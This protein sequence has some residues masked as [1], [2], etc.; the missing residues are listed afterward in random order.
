[1]IKTETAYN[2]IQRNINIKNKITRVA[3]RESLGRYLAEDIKSKINIP[4]QD[5]SAVDGIAINYSKYKNNPN[6]FYEIISEINAG[7][8]F[9][10]KIG[11]NQCV[12]VSTGAHLPNYLDTVIMIEDV[13]FL[14]N[15]LVELP[16]ILT[17]K[18]N[19]RKKGE[20]VKK[21]KIIITKKTVLRSQEIGLLASINKIT[22][23]VFAKIKIAL[24]SNGNELVNPGTTK[25]NNQIYDSN[26][27]MLMDLLKLPCNIITDSGILNDDYEKIKRKIITLKEKNDLI[28]ISGGASVGH[29]DYVV[30]IIKKIGKIIFSSLAIKPGRP[31]S[32]GILD[33]KVPI[34]ILPGN[35]VASFVTFY[36]FGNFILNCM[37]GLISKRPDFFLVK[38]NFNMMKKYGREEYLRG[39]LLRKKNE[40]FVNKYSTEGA[41]ILSSVVWSDGLIK[42]NAETKQIKVNDYLQFFPYSKI[43]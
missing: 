26:R 31:M 43:T 30:K 25:K 9:K 8:I 12:K 18:K 22:I 32:F 35:P 38:S 7:D 33:N 36:L 5:N 42:L 39:K 2:L 19:V 24:V 28:V 34:L 11:K 15:K 3:L 1:M 41:G 10:K 40:L 20:D 23:K 17:T 21:G 27:F 4:P 29:K 14:N 37:H 6:Y 13:K 16:K